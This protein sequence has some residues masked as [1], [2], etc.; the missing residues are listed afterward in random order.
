MTL[1]MILH[2]ALHLNMYYM[3]KITK[4]EAIIENSKEKDK[5]AIYLP[6]GK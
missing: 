4:K 5:A 1:R 3:K 6:G 2:K